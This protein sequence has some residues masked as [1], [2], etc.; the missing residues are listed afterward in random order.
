MYEIDIRNGV[1]TQKLHEL[2]PDSLQRA[3]SGQLTEEAG[4]IPSFTFSVYPQNTCYDALREMQTFVTLTNTK[5]GEAEFRGRVLKIS[6]AMKQNGVIGKTVTCEGELGYLCDSCLLYMDYGTVDILIFLNSVLARHNALVGEAQQIRM[7]QCDIHGVLPVKTLGRRTLEEIKSNLVDVLGGEL[8]IRHVDGVRYLDYLKESGVRS[9]VAIELTKNMK[10]LSRSQD[11]TAMI[12]RLMPLGARLS[13]EAEE[14]LT[15]A[16]VNMNCPYIDDVT[17][18][19]KY[20]VLCGVAEF[21]DVTDPAVLMERGREYLAQNNRIKK[22]YRVEALDLSTIGLDP[23]AFRLCN[24][25]PVRNPVMGVDEWLRIYKRT[26]DIYKPY[27]PALEFGDKQEAL[28]DL[29]VRTANYIKYEAPQQ[30][31]E[32]LTLAKENAT[33][34]IQAG[35]KGYVVVNGSEIL[36]MDTPDKATAQKVWRWNTGGLGYSS[37]GYDGTYGTAITMDGAIVADYIT[38]GVLRGIEITNGDGTFRVDPDG[39]CFAESINI[40]GGSIHINTGDETYSVIELNSGAWHASY[41]PLEWRLKN[42]STGAEIVAQA[43]GIFF[44]QNGVQKMNISHS[45]SITTS[46]SIAVDGGLFINGGSYDTT[47][48]SIELRLAS[49]ENRLTEGGL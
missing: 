37:T 28:T 19:E 1:T 49:L 8:S 39:N 38:A 34:L 32:I 42:D 12:T 7:G 26:V 43:G 11:A 45:G 41:A 17:A 35:I 36:I 21:D 10:S 24:T 16:G 22:A 44:Y 18:L 20:G 25:H 14:R 6:D 4:L 15:I 27:A 33:A 48:Q 3:A 46:G 13:D 47:I 31:T 9:S 23:A 2:S 40:T 30:R 29:N 5:T